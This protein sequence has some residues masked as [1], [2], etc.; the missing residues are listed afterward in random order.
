[1]YNFRKVQAYIILLS[2]IFVLVPKVRLEVLTIVHNTRYCIFRSK[3]RLLTY[4]DITSIYGTTYRKPVIVT[5][6]VIRF[7]LLEDLKSVLSS[8]KDYNSETLKL[9]V[10]VLLTADFFICSGTLAILWLFIFLA[11]LLIRIVPL[12]SK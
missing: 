2:G 7:W 1:M 9:L 11:I 4:D 6:L 5:K 10:E 3:L 8:N 12:C